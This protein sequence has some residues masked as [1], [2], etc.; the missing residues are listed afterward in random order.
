M[1]ENKG[2]ESVLTEDRV[3]PPSTEFSSG[4]HVSDLASYEALVARATED[5]VGFWEEQAH[6]LEW[7]EKW[8]EPLTWKE[9]H[10]QW[11]VGGKINAS[12]N[13][14]DRHVKSGAGDKNAIIWEGEPGEVR[15]V[16]YRELAESVGRIGRV[17]DELGVKSGDRVAIYMPMIPEIAVAMHIALTSS[18]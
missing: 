5:P 14:V 7:A 6:S 13:C 11:F 16:T 12:V 9:P 17:L 3:F 4:A 18:V 1:D 10:A 8:T 2:I 15:K